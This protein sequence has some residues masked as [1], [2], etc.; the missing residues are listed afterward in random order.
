MSSFLDRNPIQFTPY[1][2]QLPEGYAQLLSYKQAQYNEGI[3]KVDSYLQSLSGLDVVRDVDQ[4]Y[5]NGRIDNL[6]SEINKT[7]GSTDWSNKVVQNQVGSLASKIY[8]DPKIQNAVAGTFRYKKLLADIGESKRSGKGYSVQNEWDALSS[9]QGWLGNQEA[10]AQYSGKNYSP[11]VDVNGKAQEYLK[12]I[13]PNWIV[14]SDPMSAVKGSGGTPVAYQMVNNK[15]EYI[16]PEE[17]KSVLRGLLQPEDYNQLDINGR[18]GN[19]FYT[20]PLAFKG[21]LDRQ[22][23]A[24]NRGLQTQIEAW[25][26]QIQKNEND[27]NALY[28]LNNLIAQAENQIENTNRT[29]STLRSSVD[30]G[31]MEGVKSQMYL[32]EWLESWGQS[33]G[34]TKEEVTYEESPAWKGVLAARKEEREWEKHRSDLLKTQYEI[35]KLQAETQNILSGE[36]KSKSKNSESPTAEFSNLTPGGLDNTVVQSLKD[37][38]FAE[39]DRMQA[40]INDSKYTAAYDAF[41]QRYGRDSE[42]LNSLFNVAT[43]NGKTIVRPKAGKENE[44]D[45]ELNDFYDKWQANSSSVSPS[46]RTFFENKAIEERVVAARKKSANRII[47]QANQ[48]YKVSDLLKDFQGL[49]LNLS[50]NRVVYSPEE[51]LNLSNKIRPLIYGRTAGSSS[52]GIAVGSNELP[53]QEEINSILTTDKERYA[54]SVFMKNYLGQPLNQAE[55]ALLQRIGDIGNKAS[56]AARNLTKQRNEYIDQQLN[57]I[58][59][60]EQSGIRTFDV[61]KPEQT[62]AAKQIFNQVLRSRVNASGNRVGGQ[63]EDEL[64]EANK[65]FKADGTN[66]EIVYNPDGSAKLSLFNTDVRNTP[67]EINIDRGVA[68]QNGLTVIDPYRPIKQLMRAN[69]TPTGVL[70]TGTS[71]AE[72]LKVDNPYLK[73]YG[74]MYNLKQNQGGRVSILFN[75]YDNETKEW[76]RDQVA[77]EKGNFDSVEAAMASLKDPQLDALIDLALKDNQ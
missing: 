3:Q 73:K 23:K 43:V 45:T 49:N 57:P 67:L 62:R 54:Y 38:F 31:N 33:Y 75:V 59:N 17:V 72:A 48:L 70:Y 41:L 13:K 29:Y 46:I 5:L 28:Q 63:F 47:S 27:Q 56:S 24:V 42:K 61:A 20:D 22:Q 2:S 4:K 65:F 8:N 76:V 26:G 53:T 71:R 35:A 15:K 6:T 52:T 25:K 14:E 12:N 58:V 37:N 69:R 66:Y 74:L 51:M 30:A 39:T 64:E 68:S 34:Y 55:S 32:N 77:L 1:Q 11:Y 7:A 36:S 60:V 21:E 9:V 50:G 10:G 44:I 19:R 18:Y 40:D 16:K